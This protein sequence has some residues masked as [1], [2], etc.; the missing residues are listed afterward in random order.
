MMSILLLAITNFLGRF[1]KAF[2]ESL[3]WNLD[4]ISVFQYEINSW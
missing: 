1:R 3:Y 4:I 2:D